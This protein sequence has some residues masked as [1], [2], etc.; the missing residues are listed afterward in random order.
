MPRRRRRARLVP[1]LATGLL[2]LVACG[3]RLPDQAFTP[4][5]VT[6][7]AGASAGAAPTAAAGDGG[8]TPVG[9]TAAATPGGGS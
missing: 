1:L 2:A 5:G 4:A 6:Q 9:S 8:V 3:T 7:A